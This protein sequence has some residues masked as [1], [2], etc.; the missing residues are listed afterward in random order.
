MKKMH[1]TCAPCEFDNAN[2]DVAQESDGREELAIFRPENSNLEDN[3]QRAL[4]PGIASG[5]FGGLRIFVGFGV[6]RFDRIF[7]EFV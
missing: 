2:D 1:A 6:K 7:T 3:G 4:L 5:F